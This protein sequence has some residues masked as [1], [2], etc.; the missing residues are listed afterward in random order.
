MTHTRRSTYSRRTLL[1]HG[2]R[3]AVAIGLG[4]AMGGV[5]SA[6]PS[7]NPAAPPSVR[8]GS[9][10]TATGTWQ[11]LRDM[12]VYGNYAGPAIMGPVTKASFQGFAGGPSFSDDSRYV[13]VP[14]QEGD[15][16]VIRI[17]TQSGQSTVFSYACNNTVY[18]NPRKSAQFKGYV[19]VNNTIVPQAHVL[20]GSTMA[21]AN[22]NWP[23]P[24]NGVSQSVQIDSRYVYLAHNGQPGTLTATSIQT[25]ATYTFQS[26]A[27][28]NGVYGMEI[29]RTN[30]LLVCC[31]N[32]TG[33]LYLFNL[34]PLAGG[35][36]PALLAT[37]PS[38]HVGVPN[39]NRLYAGNG[40]VIRTYDLTTPTAPALIGGAA[41]YQAPARATGYGSLKLDRVHNL[42]YATW[43]DANQSG[44]DVL[45]IGAADALRLI[46]TIPGWTQS[47][48]G[49][50][51]SC[52][53]V[54]TAV[55]PDGTKF[56]LSSEGGNGTGTR[57]HGH[58][59]R[60]EGRRRRR[61]RRTPAVLRECGNA[62]GHDGRGRL[63]RVRVFDVPLLV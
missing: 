41:V 28:W 47:G 3:L 58:L 55:S 20:N 54:D 49:G 52:P 36:A 61:G 53:A 1:R 23:K 6:A 35:A 39:G 50:T 56:A 37:M 44:T 29:D 4:E 12:T 46:T 38:Q 19:A 25:G 13:Y 40:N 26:A 7:Q 17:D 60:L 8:S 27:H 22:A 24:F 57:R 16:G 21:M 42:L 59:R 33:N 31:D 15:S 51:I 2:A 32:G 9:V 18:S 10:T 30:Q 5:A 34:A 43:G 62:T 48:P 11:K 14:T 63:R 45:A